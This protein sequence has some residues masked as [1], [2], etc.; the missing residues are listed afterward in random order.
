V[1]DDHRPTTLFVIQ[2]ANGELVQRDYA[3]VGNSGTL[4]AYDAGIHGNMARELW[5][6]P[7]TWLE[8][9]QVNRSER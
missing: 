9:V 7:G 1:S 3:V 2:L 8:A 5:F 6:S 4:H